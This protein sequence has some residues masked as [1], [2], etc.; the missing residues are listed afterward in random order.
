[1]SDHD[2][3]DLGPPRVYTAIPALY[4]LPGE[5][6]PEWVCTCPDRKPWQRHRESWLCIPDEEVLAWVR[7]NPERMQ[8]RLPVARMVLWLEKNFARKSA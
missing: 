7:Q 5:R 8:M 6:V 2:P 3:A 1:M 4:R